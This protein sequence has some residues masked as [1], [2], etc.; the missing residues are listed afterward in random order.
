M[1]VAERRTATRWF[2]GSISTA[3]RAPLAERSAVNRQVLGSIPSGGVTFYSF[4]RRRRRTSPFGPRHENRSDAMAQWQRVGF[5]IRR[6]GVRI[7]LASSSFI[8]FS[9]ALFR[10]ECELGSTKVS[11]WPNW[12]R[13]LTTNQKIGGSSPSWDIFCT[14]FSPPAAVAHIA[15]PGLVVWSACSV[16][17][18]IGAS[19]ALDPGSIPGRRT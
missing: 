1:R 10:P 18:I 6:L 14:I 17:V 9:P 13:R 7:P 3:F 5:Q 2:S 8:F 12:T 16:M 19:Q 11:L 4:W 15:R